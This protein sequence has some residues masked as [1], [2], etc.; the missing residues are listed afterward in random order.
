MATYFADTSFWIGLSSKRD[1]HHHRAL[2]WHQFV[3]RTR[4][5]ILT[6]EAIFLEWLNALADL[7]SRRVAAESCLRARA[8]A[9]IEVAPFQAASWID[10]HVGWNAE[11]RLRIDNSRWQNRL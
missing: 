5:T 2:A 4:S 9:S 10:G 6:T 11:A 8:D 7:S 3:I 1:Q